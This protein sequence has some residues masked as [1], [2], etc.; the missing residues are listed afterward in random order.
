ME[1]PG[2]LPGFCFYFYFSDSHKTNGHVFEGWYV[3]GG[4]LVG[5]ISTVLG[6]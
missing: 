2:N 3:I 6:A 4:A 1:K 5:W